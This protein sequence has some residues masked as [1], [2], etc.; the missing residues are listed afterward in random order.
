M[1]ALSCLHYVKTELQELVRGGPYWWCRLLPNPC[2]S[3]EATK[4]CHRSCVV[5]TQVHGAFHEWCVKEA[6][7]GRFNRA[8]SWKKLLPAQHKYAE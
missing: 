2:F 1:A 4:V 6:S 3:M 8:S 7:G 5:S